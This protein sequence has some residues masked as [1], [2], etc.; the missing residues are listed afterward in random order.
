MTRLDHI[1]FT[2]GNLEE[3]I[4]WYRDLFGFE[5]VESGIYPEGARWAILALNDSMIAISEYPKL[6]R[7]ARQEG[8]QQVFH[9]GLRIDNQ[10]EWTRKM[11]HYNVDLDHIAQYPHSTS[12]Y[13]RD[14]S[15]HEIEVSYSNGEP[16][17][18]S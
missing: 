1:N 5:K 9:F 10:R 13:I 17:K 15:G 6:S 4:Q 18:F 14:P 2:V 12:W 3:S 7:A 8:F 16:M 11:K